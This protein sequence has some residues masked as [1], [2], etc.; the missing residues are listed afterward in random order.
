MKNYLQIIAL[1]IFL[2]M[3]VASLIYVSNRFASF[4]GMPGI[5]S[6][7]IFIVFYVLAIGVMSSSLYVN[8]KS[9]VQHLLLVAGCGV[10][11]VMIVLIFTLLAADLA[12]LFL[13]FKPLTEGIIVVV[14]TLVLSAICF[15]NARMTKVEPVDI[16]IDNLEKPVKIAHLTDLHIGH[17]RGQQWLKGVVELTN[18]QKP[19]FVVITGDLY[20]S[21][22]NLD[23]KTVDELRNI[24]APVYFVEGNHDIYVNTLRVKGM[25]K[26]IGVHVLENQK[27]EQ[28]GIQ[29]IGLNYMNADE[30][31]R[32]EM[33]AAKGDVT[34]KSVLPTLEID[35]ARPSILLHHNPQG[36]E[37]A[38]A[39][40]IDL[41]L[42]GHTHGGQFFPAT[43]VNHY[44][45]KYNRGLYVYDAEG[46]PTKVY[47]SDGLGTT[48]PPMR[49]FTKSAI[50]I[51][52]LKKAS[53]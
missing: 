4:F 18:Q 38:N 27:E 15:V 13:H 12:N 42:S 53:H 32:D 46:K 23:Q 1:G 44:L 39:N 36:V 24:E 45:F 8:G 47:V 52:N 6:V 33:R 25:L 40:G 30:K 20:E 3:I 34:I 19:D 10:A 37:Y 17:F 29:L 26:E 31:S 49:T 22:F 41:Y 48:G 51:I 9:L 11:G 2:V 7:L 50:S 14:A 5:V 43:I 16:E 28:D 35:T 21:H